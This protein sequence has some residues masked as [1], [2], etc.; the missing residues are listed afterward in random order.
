MATYRTID[1]LP[2]IFQTPANKQYLAATLEQLTQE[3]QFTKTQGYVG[4]LVG[5][6][7]AA[8]D[9]YVI[10]PTAD[11]RDYQLEPG[12]VSLLADTN[13]VK[14][15]ITFPGITAAVGLQG[16]VTNDANRL[17]TSQYYTWDP[18]VD[19][20]KMVN[21]TEYY[22]LPTGPLPVDVYATGIPTA[23]S[24]TVTRANGVYTFSE[25]Q[26]TIQTLI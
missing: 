18:F 2:E 10:E 9:Q 15:S 20:D 17:Y 14:D 3:P 13:T 25:W 8:G 4:R 19:F 26:E 5:P 12:V 7:V 22:W 6:G 11:R 16:G 21:F 23:G 1:F 24:Y